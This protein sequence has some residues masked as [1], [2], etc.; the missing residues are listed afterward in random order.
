MKA[1]VWHRPRTVSVDEVDDPKAQEPADAMIKV[2]AGAICGS[3]LH[4]R[5]C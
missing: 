2:T 3:D 4:L 5:R 1:V